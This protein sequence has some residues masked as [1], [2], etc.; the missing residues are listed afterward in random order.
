M[1]EPDTT[2]NSEPPGSGRPAAVPCPPTFAIIDIADSTWRLGADAQR[3]LAEAVRNALSVMGCTGEVRIRIVDDAEIT[4]AH[5]EYLGE[6]GTTDVITFDLSDADEPPPAAP[7]PGAGQALT[8]MPPRMLDTDLL[9]CLDEAARQATRRGHSAEH[10]L[11]LYTV[12][13]LLH[14]LGHDD[15]EEEAAARMH[16]A[17]DRVLEAIGIGA[18]YGRPPASTDPRG[19][20]DS[21]KEPS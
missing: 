10:E 6:P 9:V 17:E 5:Q 11:L 15:H 14:C 7:T 12:H 18:I 4:E 19:G 3:W 13:G 21:G 20:E 8:G 2:D 1:N 16:Q